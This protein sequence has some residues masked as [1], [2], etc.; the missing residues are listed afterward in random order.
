MSDCVLLTSHGL[1]A[2][3]V[4]RNPGTTLRE[5]A[6]CVGITERA[7]QR[8]VCDLVEAG[9]LSRRRVGRQNTYELHPDAELKHSLLAG[10]TL[11]DMLAALAEP[12]GRGERA[13]A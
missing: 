6:Q 9:Y 10:C 8:I 12:S 4:A 7:V 11:G 1:V 5:I 13:A 2:V 3:C